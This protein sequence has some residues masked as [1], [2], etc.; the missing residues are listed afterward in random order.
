LDFS[1]SYKSTGSII[2]E[3]NHGGND[4]MKELGAAVPATKRILEFN[5][6][7]IMTFFCSKNFIIELVTFK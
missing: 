3:A 6:S 4:M 2:E 7:Q 5:D 1:D